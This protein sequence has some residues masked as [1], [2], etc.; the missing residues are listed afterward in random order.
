LAFNV[1]KIVSTNN[2]SLPPSIK[3]STCCNS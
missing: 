1:S 3:A 2:K